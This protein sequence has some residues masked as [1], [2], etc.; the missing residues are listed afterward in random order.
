MVA[1]LGYNQYQ[2][3]AFLIHRYEK[4]IS[5][6]IEIRNSLQTFLMYYDMEVTHM[7]IVT[8]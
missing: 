1:V 2:F 5:S 4:E 8:S 3:V 6:I 7:G